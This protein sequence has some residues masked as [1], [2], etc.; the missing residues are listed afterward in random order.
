MSQTVTPM[1]SYQDA[2]AALDWLSRA[3]GFRE[4]TRIM[5]PDGSVG[6][7]ELATPEGGLIMLAEPTPDYRSP[8]RHAETCADADKW[9]SVPYVVDG[10][11]V[12]VADLDAHFA[13]ARDAGATVLAPPRDTGHG[14]AY[15][16]ADP[17]GHRWMFEQLPR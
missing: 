9:L 10:V 3:F 14:R 2:A 13:V 1:I 4:V 12:Y 5:M 15:T 7:G 8:R 6:H 16:V 11:H 17:E